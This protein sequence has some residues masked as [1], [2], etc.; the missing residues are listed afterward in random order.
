MVG[1]SQSNKELVHSFFK[2]DLNVKDKSIWECK[3]GVRRQKNKYGYTNLMSHIRSDHAQQIALIEGA[4][5]GTDAQALITSHFQPKKGKNIHAWIEIVVIDLHP[6]C[7]VES[8][9]L[10]RHVSIEPISINTLKKY[11]T[12]LVKVV[13]EKITALLPEKFCLIFDGWSNG[14][15]HYLGVFA[16]YP[17]ENSVGYERVLLTFSPLQ[18]ESSLKAEEHLEFMDY[19]LG[20][21]EKSWDNVVALV[22]DNCGTNRKTARIV[23]KPLVGCASHRYNLAVRQ[24]VEE[25]QS[26]V[27]QVQQL[28]VQL[29]TLI[30]AAKLRKVTDLRAKLSCATRW[31]SVG[32]M[33]K[34]YIDLRPFL[35]EMEMPSIDELV[36]SATAHRDIEEL[37]S[38]L[39][40]LRSISLQTQKEGTT[41]ADVRV[42]FDTTIDEHPSLRG[43]LGAHADIVS[44]KEFES[45]VVLLQRQQSSA[46][47]IDQKCAVKSL[48]CSP[49]VSQ[50]TMRIDTNSCLA[51]R[52]LKR[53]RTESVDCRG[54]YIDTRFI[55][56]TSNMVESLFSKAGYALTDRRRGIQPSNFEAQVYL[57]VNAHM[58][59]VEDVS[60]LLR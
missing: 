30:G 35:A 23:N 27:D 52:A 53:R 31:D 50:A 55:L 56:P 36:P 58:W 3:C 11:M 5:A 41:L 38:T 18:D 60:N 43:R 14:D 10:R 33:L 42:F 54:D 49:L 13:E 37:S 34:R 28:M 47:S 39:E 51:Q 8:E 32:I 2:R 21:Y 25:S 4:G 45:A 44:S 22:G 12:G 20:L 7:I 9:V 1:N 29:R 19:I 59:G 15:T 46:L 6:F 57:H 26:L 16:T 48:T 24:V 40:D 17:S